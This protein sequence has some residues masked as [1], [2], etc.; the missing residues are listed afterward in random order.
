MIE[1]NLDIVYNTSIKRKE[2]KIMKKQKT[3]LHIS[4]SQYYKLLNAEYIIY[5]ALVPNYNIGIVQHNDE[6]YYSKTYYQKEDRK[7]L[8][9]ETTYLTDVHFHNASPRCR[10]A[11]M[12]GLM[13]DKFSEIFVDVD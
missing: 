13:F 6:K 2:K 11:I 1:F 9:I 4:E 12:P 3:T 5:R 8:Y 7:I 10:I